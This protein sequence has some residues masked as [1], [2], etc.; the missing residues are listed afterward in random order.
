MNALSALIGSFVPAAAA[1]VPPPTPCPAILPGC[2]GPTNVL[3]TSLIPHLVNFALRLIGGLSVVM[4]IWYG[5][6][7]VVNAGDETRIGKARYAILYAA[8]GVGLSVVAQLIVSFVVTEN[9]GQ[10]ATGDLMLGVLAS[11]VRILLNV[12]NI[13]F[14]LLIVYEG[15]RMVLS[16]GKTDEYNKARTGILWSIIGAV[17]VNL[18]HALVRLVTGFFGV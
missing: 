1:Q 3:V 7:L 2:G 5:L 6:M 8:M 14:T 17:I 10:G 12:T 18:A 11:A 9:Y 16:Q 4:I 15:V 13:T